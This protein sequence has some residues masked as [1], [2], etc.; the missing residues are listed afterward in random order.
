VVPSYYTLSMNFD[1]AAAGV[2][3]DAFESAL[4]AEGLPVGHYVP[5]PIPRWER[6]RTRGYQGPRTIWTEHLARAGVDYSREGYP[7]C[8]AKVAKSLD[9]DW[10]YIRF[11]RSRMRRMADV[12][13]KVAENIAALRDWERRQT[14][15]APAARA[16]PSRREVMG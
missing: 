2:T 15:A 7:G 3:R 12:F 4:V 13:F 14:P 16:R 5:S 1:A 11:D 9:M 10:N 8:E 6:L